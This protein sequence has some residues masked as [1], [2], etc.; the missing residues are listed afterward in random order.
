MQSKGKAPPFRRRW[1]IVL[2][3][4]AGLLILYVISGFLIV[5]RIVQ[6]V[7]PQKL[8][9]LTGRT[10]TLESSAFN[11]FTLEITLNIFV[12]LEEDQTPF[13]SVGR[14]YAIVQLLPL[15]VGKAVLK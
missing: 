9:A 13:T 4:V 1:F 15:V 7:M 11:P 2:S 3:V 14:F 10:V 5:P 6:T 12:I 8:S